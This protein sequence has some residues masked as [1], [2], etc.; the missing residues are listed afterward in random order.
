MINLFVQWAIN[1]I[2]PIPHNLYDKCFIITV[3]DY[4]T[5]WPIACVTKVH[6][7]KAIR[8]FIKSKINLKFR[9][10]KILII[11]YGR[12]FISFNTQV[13]L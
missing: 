3:I 2:R 4:C 10:P 12:E 9:T 1:V 13:Y 6:D 8:I 5:C 7:G 11:D